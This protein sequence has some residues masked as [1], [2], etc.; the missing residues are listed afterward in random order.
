MN[1]YFPLRIISDK[2]K[3]DFMNIRYFNMGISLLLL[4]ASIFLLSFKGLNLGIDFKGGTVIEAKLDQ[5]AEFTPLYNMLHDLNLGDI[6]LQNLDSNNIMIKLGNS[7]NETQDKNISILKAAL[8]KYFDNKIEYSKIEF[9]GPQV[10]A[11]LIQDGIMAMLFSFIG[12]MC[13]I[14]F[15]FEWQYGLGIIIALTH[16]TV[17]TLGFMSLT[18]LEFDLTSIAA[19]LTV[20][21]YSVN[22]SVVIYDRIRENILKYKKLSVQ[23][24]INLSINETLGRTMLTVLTTLISVGGLIIFGGDKLHSFSVTVFF[25]IVVGTYSSIYISA[26]ILIH[27]GIKKFLR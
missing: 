18:G 14:A 8:N 24:M 4:L 2:T 15:R 6:H 11:A 26:P 10:G 19:V 9:V 27:L 1:I 16:D 21:G 13:Y 7:S 17:F 23:D 3:I 25:G 20:I 22:D 12:I 5:K